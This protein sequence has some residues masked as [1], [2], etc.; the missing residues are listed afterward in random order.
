MYGFIVTFDFAFWKILP[1]LLV[2]TLLHVE[3]FLKKFS[4]E[5][6]NWNIKKIGQENSK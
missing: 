5:T 3:H 4:L 2:G 6:M 1:S